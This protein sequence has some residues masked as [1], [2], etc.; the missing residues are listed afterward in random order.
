M[1]WSPMVIYFVSHVLASGL[2]V[3]FSH[4]ISLSL[5]QPPVLSNLFVVLSNLF[6]AA[7]C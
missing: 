3:G 1:I 7:V 5:N 4:T 6:V 2:L